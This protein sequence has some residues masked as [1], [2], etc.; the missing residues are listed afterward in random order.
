MNQSHDFKYAPFA[1]P[2]GSA[3]ELPTPSA[4][5]QRVPTFPSTEPAL[6]TRRF[7]RKR[8]LRWF[9]VA[10][11]L[12][13]ALFLGIWLTPPLRLKWSPDPEQWVSVTSLPMKVVQ[14][15]TP[16]AVNV[17]KPAPAQ[18]KGHGANPAVASSPAQSPAI[19]QS[20][21]APISRLERSP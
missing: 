4:Y 17:T 1:D 19:Q 8:L 12:H 5:R 14:P 21:D 15:P 3:T 7:E 11:A 6:K 10:V 20:T 18:P 2:N 9:A 13:A 16:D